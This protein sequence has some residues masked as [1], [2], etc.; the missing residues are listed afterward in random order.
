MSAPQPEDGA[1]RTA[2]R[3][4]TARFNLVTVDTLTP[5]GRPRLSMRPAAERQRMAGGKTMYDRLT[6]GRRYMT[7]GNDR[8]SGELGSANALTRRAGTYW[9]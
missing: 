3:H 7:G 1:H 2:R 8:S 4:R 5:S 6:S 9:A